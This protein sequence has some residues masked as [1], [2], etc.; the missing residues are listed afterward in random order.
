M[1]EVP[2]VRF[3]VDDR[4]RPNGLCDGGV[5]ADEAEHGA[6]V[7]PSAGY[8]R[9]QVKQFAVGPDRVAERDGEG[10]LEISP[11]EPVRDRIERRPQWIA[12]GEVQSG[13][14][15]RLLGRAPAGN[16]GPVLDETA[17]IAGETCTII[18]LA[19]ERLRVSPQRGAGLGGIVGG[20]E[21]APGGEQC[22]AGHLEIDG[23]IHP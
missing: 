13:Q 10:L 12:R 23:I 17:V 2:H 5:E 3:G 9:L 7:S 21:V 20:D 22:F 19:G 14:T 16:N 8:G 6:T 1:L 4:G 18:L 11:A 15:V